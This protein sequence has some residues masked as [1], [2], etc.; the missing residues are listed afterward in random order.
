MADRKAHLICLPGLFF[1]FCFFFFWK[2]EKGEKKPSGNAPELLG[3]FV[4][5]AANK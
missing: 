5:A 3:Q 1:I 2:G 4:C